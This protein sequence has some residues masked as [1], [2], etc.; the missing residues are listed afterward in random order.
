M[1]RNL[2]IKARLLCGLAILSILSIISSA[3]AIVSFTESRASIEALYQHRLQGVA[4]LDRVKVG[5]FS[6]QGAILNA[7]GTAPA[8]QSVMDGF[9]ADLNLTWTAYRA[10]PQ[11]ADTRKQADAFHASWQRLAADITALGRPDSVVSIP[12]LQH[13]M[14]AA[15]SLAQRITTAQ[16]KDAGGTY[17][18]TLEDFAFSVRCALTVAAVSLIT[19]IAVGISLVRSIST[20]LKQVIDTTEAIAAGDLTQSIHVGSRDEIGQISAALARMQDGIRRMVA[21]VRETTEM[22]QP[23]AADMAHGSVALAE[24]NAAQVTSLAATAASMEQL[25]ATVQQNAD[26]A[27]QANALVNDAALVATRGGAAVG[28]VVATMGAISTASAKIVDI[29]SVI[30]SI[31]FQTNLLALNA[32]VEAARAGGQGRGFAVVAGEVRNLAQRSTQAAKEIKSLIGKSAAQVQ[33][34]RKLVGQTGATIDEVVA[35]V[36]RVTSMVGDITRAS[37]EQYSGIDKVGRAIVE[38][39]G[40]NQQNAMMVQEAAATAAAIREQAQKLA[41]VV[42]RFRLA[43]GPA[44]ADSGKGESH[45]GALML[46][47]DL[48]D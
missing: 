31:A 12:A 25:T 8:D 3:G 23:L 30:D 34:G 32:A 19:A 24:R 41:S 16:A 26:N 5:L 18:Q 11:S 27:Q 33:D 1:L 22:L 36:R 2:S 45:S 38:M 15:I 6:I 29:I 20:P 10:L 42:A 4:L 43:A 44:E 7:G 9:V 17:R 37:A 28:E 21:D 13:D 46:V 39:D 14:A 47:N 35:S 40:A 48:A